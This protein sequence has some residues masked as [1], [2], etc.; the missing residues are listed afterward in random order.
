MKIGL[1]I[2]GYINTKEKL[3][4]SCK[5]IHGS[6]E[7]SPNTHICPIC[8]GQP[9]AKPLNPNRI[10]V[11]RAIQIGLILGCKINK[12]PVWQRK[13]YSWPDLPKGYQNTLSGPHAIPTGEKGKFE[14]INIT[15][16]H[17]E[18]DP[19]AWNPETG[20]IDYN[21]S[22]SPLIEVV[23]E[24]EFKSA[25]QVI[26]WLE[27]LKATLSY[28]KSIDSKAGIK[29]DVN[30]S[31]PEVKGERVE[32]KNVNS[33]ENVQKAIEYEIE[34]QIK[35][36][37]VTKKQETRR[38]DESKGQTMKMRTKEEAKDYRFIAD[39]DLPSLNL[40]EEQIEKIEEN[41]PET[42]KEKIQKLIKKHEI[43][44]K[45]AQILTKKLELVELFEE[46][47]KETSPE[48][49]IHWITI[50][51]LGVLNHNKTSL[52][53]IK[54]EI[55]SEHFIEL[56]KNIEDKKITKQK[57]QEILRKFIPKSFSPGKEINKQSK[58]SDNSE[59]EQWV[60][61]AIEEN[62]EA[63]EDYRNG[64]E[65]SINFLIGQVMKLS[66]KRADFKIVKKLLEEKLKE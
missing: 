10:A 56:L 43:D 25:E 19:A 18:E 52:E 5:A 61:Q 13:H 37:E 35:K 24:P 4:C 66:Q 44:K 27:S 49:A 64:E 42:P 20:R 50:E 21:R 46:T 31:F 48:T 65:K 2:H 15:E 55:K 8:T 12:K 47:I 54:T 36:K 26:E 41:M 7:A 23:T 14:G 63:V 60:N 53:N 3:F 39:P 40:S 45:S 28:I 9:G 38:F 59:I 16:I 62:P 6:K 33:L 30:I 57:G 51:L 58:I 29:A 22:G 1:E 32:I 17:L 34:R 11:E